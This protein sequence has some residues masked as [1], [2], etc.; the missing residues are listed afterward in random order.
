MKT[1]IL[2]GYLTVLLTY[3]VKTGSYCRVRGCGAKSAVRDLGFRYACALAARTGW[4]HF[5]VQR[6][7]RYRS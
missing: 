6:V 3:I 5:R 7:R 4:S 1:Y 2:E